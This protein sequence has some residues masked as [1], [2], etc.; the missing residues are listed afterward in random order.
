MMMKTAGGPGLVSPIDFGERKRPLPRWAWGAIAASLA[1]HGVI[2]V[3]LY[4]QRFEM[5]APTPLPEGPTIQ[6]DMFRPKPPPPI[7][8][9][10]PAPPAPTPPIHI[11]TTV[12]PTTDTVSVT[13]SDDPAPVTGTVINLTNPVA[14]D[15]TGMATT[16]DVP[17]RGPALITNPTWLRKPSGAQLMDAYPDRAIRN[18]VSGSATLRCAVRLDGSLTGCSVLAETPGGYG[19]GRSALSLSRYFRMNPGA[20]DG[21]AIDGARVNVGVRFTLPED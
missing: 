5:V 3:A 16:P 4:T 2:G 19:F 9:A 12:Q 10:D 1:V 17:A 7:V 21:Q 18:D 6:V 8:K 14:S 20:V 11:P 13:P 15:A